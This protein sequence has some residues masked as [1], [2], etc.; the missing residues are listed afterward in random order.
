[1]AQRIIVKNVILSYPHLDKPVASGEGG[2]A[3]FSAAFVFGPGQEAQV[4]SIKEAALGVLVEKFGKPKATEMVKNSSVGIAGGRGHAVRTDVAKYEDLGGIA[5]INARSADKPGLVSLIPDSKGKPS[6]ADVSTF[7]AGSIVNASVTP[8]YYDRNGNRGVTWA[9]NNLQWVGDG[10]K[11][12]D[13]RMGA[14]DEFSSD[15]NAVASL[16]ALTDDSEDAGEDDLS[17][18]LG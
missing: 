12:L 11:R 3:K 5:F 15:P 1:M 9:L 10:E 18:L 8:Y 2:D 13:S 14:Q 17:D 4:K 7:Y 16:D 6:L